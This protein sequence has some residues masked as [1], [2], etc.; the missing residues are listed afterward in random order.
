MD[1]NTL[2]KILQEKSMCFTVSEVQQMMEE[3]LQKS[4]EIMDT[5]LVDLCLEVLEKAENAPEAD[6]V[7]HTDIKEPKGKSPKTIKI[8]RALLIAAVVVALVVAAIPVSAKFVHSDASDE[9][10]QYVN[11]HFRVDLR[12]GQSNADESANKNADLVAQFNENGVDPVILPACFLDGTSYVCSDVKVSQND[13]AFSITTADI[14]STSNDLYGTIGITVYKANDAMSIF[15]VSDFSDQYDSV[16][17]LTVNDMDIL[18]FG[19]LNEAFIYYVDGNKEYEITLQNCA[20]EQAV[21][22]AQTIL[23]K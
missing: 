21:Q 22:I 23:S 9:I 8:A 5:E 16:K 10:V 12:G 1:I 4:P 18:V 20:F 7:S 3:E 17:Q 19:N 2:K 14:S 15:G 6:I 13:D 11:D